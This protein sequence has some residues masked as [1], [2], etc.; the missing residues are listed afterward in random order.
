VLVIADEVMTGFGRTGRWFASEHFDLRPDIMTMAKGASS[1]YWP[2]GICA[3]SNRVASA[4][5]E[6]GFVHG[7]T[8]SHHPVGAAAGLAVLRRIDELRL[9]AAAQ[10]KG[11]MLIEM[12]RDVVGEDERVGDIRG[13]GLLIAVELVEDRNAKRPFPRSAEMAKRMT[14]QARNRG[15]LVYPSTGAAGNGLGDVVMIGPP[16]TVDSGELEMLVSK[17]ALALEGLR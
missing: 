12:L 17:F 5:A 1:G 8:F 6:T 14:L 10:T 2:L 7:F 15:L 9:V 13:L 3:T 16:L 11:E 4:I